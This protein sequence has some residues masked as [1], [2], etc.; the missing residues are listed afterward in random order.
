M[1]A[2]HVDRARLVDLIVGGGVTVITAPP[3]WGKTTLLRQTAARTGGRLQEP[4]R[5]TEPD[6]DAGLL[7]VDDPGEASVAWQVGEGHPGGL[8]LATPAS[9]STRLRADRVIGTADLAFTTAEI[10]ELLRSAGRD[11]RYR[12]AA[13]I[14]AETWGWPALVVAAIDALDGR[15]PLDDSDPDALALGPTRDR[16]V[17][18]ALEVLDEQDEVDLRMLAVLPGWS[19]GGVRAVLGA[20]SASAV[21][22][23][24]QAGLLVVH[25][26]PRRVAVLRPIRDA[27]HAAGAGSSAELDVVLQRVG[28]AE[29]E[30]AALRALAGD[31]TGVAH[32]LGRDL[33]A[34][35]EGP[36]DWALSLPGQSG[37]FRRARAAAVADA[38]R[39]ASMPADDGAVEGPPPAAPASLAAGFE[40]APH[41]LRAIGVLLSGDVRR[42]LR[43]LGAP[44]ADQR[45][46]T[47]AELLVAALGSASGSDGD[48]R[49]L[50]AVAARAEAGGL[51]RIARIAL[52]AA[53]A[54]GPGPHERRLLREI[55]DDCER[56]GDDA[57]VALL[58]AFDLVRRSFAGTPARREATALLGR[59]EPY[60]SPTATAWIAALLALAAIGDADAP[61]LLERAERSAAV[62]R[63]PGPLALAL[64][65]RAIVFDGDQPRLRARA[66]QRA[67]EAG[68]L[69][70]PFPDRWRP[71]RPPLQPLVGM[72]QGPSIRIR[73][74]GRFAVSLDEVELDLRRMRPQARLVLRVLA[75]SSERPVHRD[76]LLDLLSA[77]DREPA[78]LHALHVHLS[79]I[80]SVFRDATPQ[81]L[82]RHGTAYSLATAERSTSDVAEFDASVARAR[83][84]IVATDHPL[85]KWHLRTAL[86]AYQG[87]LL[88][89]DGGAEWVLALRDRYVLRAAEAA[90]T[91]AELELATGDLDAAVT[92]ATRSCDIAP[93]RDSSWRLLIDAHHRRGDA[94]S[95]RRARSEYRDVL[96]SLGV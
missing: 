6:L 77:E 65:A 95:A 11:D 13:R 73:C 17:R 81:I 8:V 53:A 69:R 78:S 57:A 5:P 16:L 40:L 31:W 72:G 75:A 48:R 96:H 29:P 91:L 90:S 1:S 64:G 52:G 7:L 21:A 28:P 71:A 83:P 38:G 63:A 25:G 41:L 54:T 59:I 12:L 61:V 45:T 47:V 89:E 22:R 74:F 34:A 87:D 10:A 51:D 56:C 79:S 14:R 86:D 85:A 50:E 35:L 2:P 18:A 60:G 39:T 33:R 42:A 30:L 37:A 24:E 27:L 67:L 15:M 94:S 46:A 62:A 88:P 19:A 55:V 32:A 80:R 4:P 49:R 9:P 3:G 20:R 58:E 92:A 84:A 44:A 23:L 36:R 68:M 66:R 82:A 26:P 76:L 93:W 43:L 70:L